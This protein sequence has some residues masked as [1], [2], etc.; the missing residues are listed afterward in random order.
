MNTLRSVFSVLSV[1][2][3]L[4]P[5]VIRA[6]AAGDFQK[7]IESY[8][9]GNHSEAAKWFRKA[10]DQGYASAQLY[11]GW[12]YDAGKGVT[13]DHAKALKWTRR[14]A[15]QGLV[16]AQFNLGVMYA[17]GNG[18]I[19]DYAEAVKWYRRAADQGL[20]EAQYN[21]GLMYANGVLKDPILAHMWW[22]IAAFMG[23]KTAGKKRDGL[24]E[25]M[26]AASIVKAT[27]KAKR[28]LRSNYKNCD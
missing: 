12:S 16:E 4:A 2:M 13:K 15:D 5:S 9:Q 24:E 1:L 6:D 3:I 23:D 20:V 17:N 19:K 27:Q 28:C 26:N 22:N 18:V 11:L 21:L 25:T 10:A 14:A 8:D 7:G